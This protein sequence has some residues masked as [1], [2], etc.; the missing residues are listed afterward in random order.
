MSITCDSCRASSKTS[1][2]RGSTD[3]H[4]S[5]TSVSTR[6]NATAKGGSAGGESSSLKQEEGEASIVGEEPR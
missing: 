6:G 1:F 3:G 4:S 2:T 5:G